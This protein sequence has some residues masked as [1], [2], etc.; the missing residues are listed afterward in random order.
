M[1]FDARTA[2]GVVPG[3]RFTTGVVPGTTL[4]PAW[5]TEAAEARGP[6]K[7]GLHIDSLLQVISVAGGP[8]AIVLQPAR[9]DAG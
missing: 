9:D 1:I 6:S 3:I 4:R 8:D 5:R 2:T 7:T